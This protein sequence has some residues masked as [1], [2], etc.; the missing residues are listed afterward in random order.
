MDLGGIGAENKRNIRWSIE[1]Q[2]DLNSS[3]GV[4]A[5]CRPDFVLRCL[6]RSASEVRPVAIF[7]DGLEH[8]RFSQ[9]E[10]TL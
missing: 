10:D 3:D 8:H 7:A 9:S 2:V 5:P 6:S 1:P 4:Y